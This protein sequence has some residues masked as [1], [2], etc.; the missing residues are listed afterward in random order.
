MNLDLRLDDKHNRNIFKLLLYLSHTA[1]KYYNKQDYKDIG[2]K[3]AELTRVLC[4]LLIKVPDANNY[5]ISL[6][7][8]IRCLISLSLYKDAASICCHLEPKDLYAPQN[9]TIDVLVKISSLWHNPI[10]NIY[11]ILN[12][13]TLNTANYNQLKNLIKYE[14]EMIRITYKNYTKHLIIRLNT[15]LDKIAIINKEIN[16]YFDDFCKYVM[17]CLEEA[18]LYFDEADKYVIYCHILRIICRIVSRIINTTLIQ[19]T[20]KILNQLFNYFMSLLLRD[21]ECCQC[22]QQFQ[23][24]CIIFL[25]PVENFVSDHAKDMRNVIDFNLKIV[26]KY[27]YTGAL[28]W[29]ALSISELIETLF[30]SW[31]IYIKI[32][33]Q[34]L[35]SGI[36]LETMN[37]VIHVSTLF[38]K[39]VLNK[40]RSCLNEDCTIKNDVYNAVATKC[41][42]INLLCKF[43]TKTLS[44]DVCVLAR[45]IL[46]QT[47]VLIHEMREYKCKQWTQLWSTCGILIYNMG[48]VSEHVYEESAYL[49]SLLCTCIFQFD[50]TESGF[51]CLAFENPISSVLHR[52]SAIHYTNGIYREAMTASALNALLSYNQPNTKAFSMWVNIKK[53]C[54]V[55]ENTK[56]SMLECLKNDKE[57]IS[58]IGLSIDISNYDLIQLC[59]REARSLLEEKITFTNGVSAVIDE[60]KKLK[61]NDHQYAQVIQLLGH[62]LLGS[63]HDSSVLEYYKLTISDLKLNGL[64]SMAV[65]CLEAN[66]SFFMFVEELHIMN[67]QTHT[68]IENTKFALYA[69]KLPELL[70]TK[71][72]NVVPAY[73]MINIK[74][75]SSLMLNMQNSLKKWSQL[76]TRDMV[77]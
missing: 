58:K 9:G 54:T 43:P 77:S 42:C 67:K 62:Y 10:N 45:R 12:T 3:I 59:L 31:E 46:E 4:S 8:I 73:T 69:P 5:V 32:Y 72:P 40:C 17:D 30:T 53:K 61:P 41:R 23:D 70:E 16:T 44:K 64:N 20:V 28:K 21:E 56:L 29:N 34:F 33:K 66:L 71:S 2:K 52:L 19:R 35:D 1:D 36:L 7:H 39:Q 47:V 63:D 11:M 38:T 55:E 26:E 18:Q 27:G 74:K 14:V 24:L 48:I 15:Y 57:K 25:V 76:F 13:E 75:V 22:F 50:E 6:Y 49:F 37:L 65:L 68:E 60:L 51:K